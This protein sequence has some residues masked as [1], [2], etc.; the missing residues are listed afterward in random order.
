MTLIP[1]DDNETSNESRG[2]CRRNDKGRFVP[3]VSL[4]SFERTHEPG[5][6]DFRNTVTLGN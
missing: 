6:V 1:K 3:N 2:I 5:M 4:N